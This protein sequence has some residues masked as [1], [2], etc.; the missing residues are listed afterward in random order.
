VILDDC[1]NAN[2]SSMAA[3]LRMLASVAARRRPV[4]VLGDMLE[5]GAA[6]EAEHRALGGRAADAAA[7][8]VFF[9]PRS[10]AAFEAARTAAPVTETAHFLEV[11]PLLA[12][13]LPRLRDRDAVLVKGSRGMKLERVV[14]A[15]EARKAGASAS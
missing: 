1:Y 12:W 6:E 5:L 2:P 15:L 10:A 8:L 4:A 14:E 7:L 11:E 9:G 13:L 3:A